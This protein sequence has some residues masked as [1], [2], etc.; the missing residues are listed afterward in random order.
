MPFCRSNFLWNSHGLNK[1]CFKLF[2]YICWEL[3]SFIIHLSI[4]TNILTFPSLRIFDACI[5]KIAEKLDLR[6]QEWKESYV[7]LIT[8]NKQKEI[9]V[10]EAIILLKIQVLRF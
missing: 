6:G 3:E 9:T 4:K 10:L 5:L 2:L 1:C 8:S 7:Q